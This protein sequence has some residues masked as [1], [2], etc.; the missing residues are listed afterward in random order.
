MY[1]AFVIVF[2]TPPLGRA[3]SRGKQMFFFEHPLSRNAQKRDKTNQGKN[4]NKTKNK[5]K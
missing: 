2:F 1:V 3:T 4:K 5:M